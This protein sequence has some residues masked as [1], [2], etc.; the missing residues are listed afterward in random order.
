MRF[1]LCVLGMV[2][3]I[4]GLPYFVFS[5]KIKLYLRKLAEIPDTTLQVAGFLAI[6]V[7]VI[8][9]YLGRS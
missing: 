8:L 5:G 7:G 2:L 4:E 3:I 9:V 1:L 6:I